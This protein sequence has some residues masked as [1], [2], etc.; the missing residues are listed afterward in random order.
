MNITY[1]FLKKKIEMGE[2]SQEQMTKLF[3]EGIQKLETDG[4][5]TF[6]EAKE[7]SNLIKNMI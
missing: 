3:S 1:I 6:Y 4:D 5:I 7:L 2:L